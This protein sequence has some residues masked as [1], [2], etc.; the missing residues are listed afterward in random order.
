MP[1]ICAVG[2]EVDF[3]LCDFV[4]D[5]RA[6]TPT[7]AAAMLA[8]GR[9]EVEAEISNLARRLKDALSDQV[10]EKKR[11]LRE[12]LG[13]LQERRP[14]Y[15]IAEARQDLDRKAE[16]LQEA[17]SQ[18]L[19]DRQL[20]VQRYSDFLARV[21]PLSLVKPLR[22][23]I[24]GLE[25][26]LQAYHPHGPLKRGYAIV[27]DKKTGKILRSADET[28]K[29]ERLMIQLRKGR[30]ESEVISRETEGEEA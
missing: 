24:K 21:T 3:S 7:A 1:T 13:I 9:D 28:Q 29:G 27:S 2:H 15:L 22:E 5:L 20:E 6:P 11:D 26:Q 23:K 18:A 16:D 10:Q 12:L 30:V 17:L 4:A 25:A 8:P 19:K 14:D